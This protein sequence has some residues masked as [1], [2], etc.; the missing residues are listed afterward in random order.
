MMAIE[1]EA[2]IFD[3]RMEVVSDHLPVRRVNAR[4]I[5]PL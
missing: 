2:S 1:L 5:C 3:H 4:V